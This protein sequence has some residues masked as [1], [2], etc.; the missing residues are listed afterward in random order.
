[1]YS[2]SGHI[3]SYYEYYHVCY[4]TLEHYFCRALEKAFTNSLKL[5]PKFI[6]KHMQTRRIRMHPANPKMAQIATLE[7]SIL[8]HKSVFPMV[9]PKQQ[10]LFLTILGK[11]IFYLNVFYPI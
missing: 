5:A 7:S 4:A 10:I 9:S 3:A 1:M 6:I 8:L 2:I 11:T